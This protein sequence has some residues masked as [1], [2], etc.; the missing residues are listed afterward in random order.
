MSRFPSCDRQ[1]G[2]KHDEKR[3]PYPQIVTKNFQWLGGTA[4]VARKPLGA[5]SHN[6]LDSAP[7]KHGLCAP[8]A[9]PIHFLRESTDR[10]GAPPNATVDAKAM[11]E[12]SPA[13]CEGANEGC[14]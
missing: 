2:A 11:A 3:P 6:R 1:M 5:M 8:T 13:V 10:C 7:P 4:S 9:F 12:S 14:V